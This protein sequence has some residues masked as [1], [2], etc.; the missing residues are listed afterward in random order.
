MCICTLCLMCIPTHTPRR[1]LG[2]KGVTNKSVNP[3]KSTGWHVVTRPWVLEQDQ[4]P[5]NPSSGLYWFLT[6]VEPWKLSG[7][8]GP[9]KLV[10]KRMPYA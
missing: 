5:L 6:M 1:A 9:S 8:L 2:R 10:V 4:C 7:C 3:Y